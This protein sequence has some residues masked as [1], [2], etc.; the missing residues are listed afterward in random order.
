MYFLLF[1]SVWSSSFK[2]ENKTSTANTICCCTNILINQKVRINALITRVPF[3]Q[4]LGEIKIIAN[5][6]VTGPCSLQDQG[7]TSQ[8]LGRISG[9]VRTWLHFSKT[10]KFQEHLSKRAVKISERYGCHRE[11]HRDYGVTDSL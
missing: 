8:L 4:Q 3:P 9:R 11:K 7:H 5:E 6:K 10:W 1:F 2:A